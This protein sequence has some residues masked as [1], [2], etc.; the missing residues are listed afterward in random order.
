MTTPR[1]IVHVDMDAFYASVE[2]RDRPELRGKPVVVGGDPKKRGVIS[3]ASYE[4]REFGI[5]SAMSSAR[6]IQLCPHVVFL[7]GSM[8]KY[9]AISAKIR[10][11]FESYT[12]LVEPLSLDEAFLDVTGSRVLFGDGEKIAREIR[13]KIRTWLQ[14][15]ASAGV[16]P[17]KFLAK[18]A[19]DLDK[20][21]GLVVVPP[22]HIQDFLDPLPIERIWGVGKQTA[23]VLHRMGVT[24]IEQLRRL[25][26]ER[27]KSTLGPAS[28]EHLYRLSRGEDDRP[29]TPDREAKSISHE[30][31][32]ARDVTDSDVL[33][34][35][36]LDLVD[37]V[38]R[39]MRRH[40]LFARSVHLKV[41]FSDFKTITRSMTFDQPTD[42]TDELAD[43][44]TEIFDQRL[45][46]PLPPV[47]LIG[48]GVGHLSQTGERQTLLFGDDD[49]ERGAQLD[50][51]R[52][53]IRD[54]F[55]ESSIRRGS[56]IE[57]EK[58]SDEDNE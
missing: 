5:H 33:R 48:M 39:R 38:A 24:H 58:R 54:R 45:P 13:E 47:R 40:Q 36:L 30:T 9:S 49:H 11:I 37:Q 18:I 57:G 27:L 2:Q 28:A 55:G 44:A 50:Q 52:D 21:D 35:R 41:R 10:E 6:A 3:A 42:V 26:F 29:V 46:V 20:P 32:F 51:A 22:D 15:T 12:P 53:A 1:T 8:E 7:H 23:A 4:A 16:A 43:M 34:E 14:L 17:N 31:T 25:S 56:S 19:S